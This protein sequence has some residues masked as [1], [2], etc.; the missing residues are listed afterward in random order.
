MRLS[1]WTASGLEKTIKGFAKRYAELQKAHAELAS[2]LEFW[3]VT[4]RPISPDVGEAIA[5]AAQEAAPRHPDELKKLERF[6]HL[7]GSDLA[8]FCKLIRFED[9]QDDYWDQRNIL[10]QDVSGYLPDA[11]VDAPTQLKELVTRR[12]LS[13]GEQNPTITKIDVLRALKTD[14]SRLFPANCLIAHVSD[15]IPREQEPELIRQIV[16]AGGPVIIHASGGV[17]KSVFAT[18]IGQG[19]PQGSVCILYDCFGNGQ[20]RS[21]TGY[22]HRHK[23]ALVEIANELAAK[24]LCHLLIPA[25][26]ADAAAHVRAFL[27]RLGQAAKLLRLAN[28]NA[29]LCIVVAAADNAQ[30]AAEEIGEKRSFARDLIRANVPDGIRLV[31]LCRSH[32]QHYLD[33]PPNAMPI[34]LRPFSHSETAAFLRQKFPDA[35]EHDVDEFHRLSSQNPRVQALALSRGLPLQQTLRLLGPNPMSVEDT[36]AELLDDSIAKLKDFSGPV[37]CERVEKIC[38]GPAVLRPISRPIVVTVC[39]PGSSESWGLN[40]TQTYGTLVPVEEPSTASSADFPTMTVGLKWLGKIHEHTRGWSAAFAMTVPVSCAAHQ[41]ERR[42]HRFAWSPERV[43]RNK[44]RSRL[45]RNARVWS[46]M[47]GLDQEE[48]T[49]TGKVQPLTETITL[50]SE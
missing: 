39:M 13:E 8:A 27:Y 17:G 41:P 48:Q 31:F 19:L 50:P 46:S 14:E 6:T 40:S 3:F 22:R 45:I 37:E 28:P 11:D 1:F 32:R 36:V 4:N 42:K 25:A 16:E 49:S 20:Y 12:A 10:F 24:S 2:K 34:E 43:R 30:L 44:S 23:D 7:T 18:R 5:D 21:A 33:P 9:R 38:A 47:C 26:Y 35:S 15:A 29:L